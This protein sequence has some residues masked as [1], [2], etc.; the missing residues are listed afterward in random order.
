MNNICIIPARANSKRIKNKNIKNFCG[1]PIIYWSIQAAK[2]SKC[3][4][5]IIISSDSKK[6][7]NISEKFGAIKNNLRPRKISTDKSSMDDVIKYEIFNGFEE[8]RV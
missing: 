6:I 8:G 5:K 4:S 3:F 7:L 2:K 1:K